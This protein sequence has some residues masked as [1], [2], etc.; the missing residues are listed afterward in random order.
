MEFLSKTKDFTPTVFLACQ[1]MY[2]NFC[3]APMDVLW[4]HEYLVLQSI[5]SDV[6]PLESGSFWVV[7]IEIVKSSPSKKMEFWK[8]EF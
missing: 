5:L 1:S 8:I 7:L 2:P 3:F 6:R 4:A